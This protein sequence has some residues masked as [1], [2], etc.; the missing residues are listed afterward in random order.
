MTRLS[1][2]E[3]SRNFSAVLNRVALGEEVEVVRH[4]HP[5]AR[6]APARP[7]ALSVSAFR[8]LMLDAPAVDPEFVDDVEAAR[9]ALPPPGDPWPS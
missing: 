8:A 7:N 4:G 5:V 9:R 2:T 3:V 1:A 6:I